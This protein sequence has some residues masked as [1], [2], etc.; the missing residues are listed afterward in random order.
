MEGGPPAFPADSSCPQVLRI[1][2]SASPFRLHD[3][4]IL[5]L[6]FPS[7]STTAPL[8]FAVLTP[9]I[10]LLPV[11]PLPF[12]LATTHGISVDYFSSAY[13]DVSVRRVPS[14]SL[15][16]SENGS[17]YCYAEGCPIRISTGHNGYLR[18]TVAFRSLSR[19]SSAPNAKAF[20]LCSCLLE[21]LQTFLRFSVL[22]LHELRKSVFSLF[23]RYSCLP[24]FFG[25]TFFLY[26]FSAHLLKIFLSC[27]SL[28]D[29][30]LFYSFFNVLRVPF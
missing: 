24:F 14:V 16:H 26:A 29:L 5:R 18:L 12:S 10:F 3:S 15:F 28:P 11:W 1:P 25:K 21:L 22:F 2:R 6:G 20:S 30:L 27:C 9:G 7:H 17:A 19:P 23:F 13:L 8:R 4:H